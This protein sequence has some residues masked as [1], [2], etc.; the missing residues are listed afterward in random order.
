MK[1]I[2]CLFVLVS[3]LSLSTGCNKA[4]SFTAE[5]LQG[6]RHTMPIREVS[7]MVRSHY[8]QNKIVA[9]IQRRHVPAAIDGKTEESLIRFGAKPA[10]IAALK[11]EA[12]VLTRKQRQAFDE[13]AAHR[14]SQIA[15]ERPAAPQATEQS[16]E[17]PHTTAVVNTATVDT[18]EQAYWKAE[19]A[20]RA[21]KSDLEARIF[22]E[23]GRINRL[24]NSGA[25][26]SDLASAEARL[27]QHEDELKNLRTPMR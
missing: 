3:V 27:H 12:N 9:E 22:S 6:A 19:A 21:K 24:R 7:L 26:E 20:Y 25:H 16:D 4:Q 1:Q 17:Q 18:P 14:R 8:D 23:Q 2:R 15:N 10:L 5:E 11:N 13:L